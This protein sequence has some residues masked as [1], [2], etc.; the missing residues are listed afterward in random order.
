MCI[1]QMYENYFLNS[2]MGTLNL[3]INKI[4]YYSAFINPVNFKNMF[5]SFCFHAP[6]FR[7]ASNFI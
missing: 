2:S 6:T 5:C 4:Q 7:E 3:T 1:I